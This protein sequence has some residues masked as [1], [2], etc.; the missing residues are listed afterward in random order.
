MCL[1]YIAYLSLLSLKVHIPDTWV[2]AF[3]DLELT[4]GELFTIMA[5]QYL[6]LCF[7]AFDI[8]L[9]LLSPFIPPT[10]AFYSGVKHSSLY[11]ERSV[12]ISVHWL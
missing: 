10:A 6:C 12:D 4:T 1:K 9:C 7:S 5:L 3:D 8:T 11:T 2:H